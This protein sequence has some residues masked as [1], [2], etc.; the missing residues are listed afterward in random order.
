MSV[1]GGE[2]R[3]DDAGGNERAASRSSWQRRALSNPNLVKGVNVIQSW[4]VL[5]PHVPGDR[6]HSEK[7]REFVYYV[8]VWR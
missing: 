7:S 8:L 6:R 1:R 2:A 4:H 5:V 3:Q